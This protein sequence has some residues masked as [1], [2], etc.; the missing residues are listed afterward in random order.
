MTITIRYRF[1]V[2]LLL[3]TLLC[4][5]C[6]AR[7]A[8]PTSTRPLLG[9]LKGIPQ[10]PINQAD[11]FIY[12]VDYSALESA[13]NATRPADA[14]EFAN[15]R[16]GDVSH[17]VWGAVWRN[18]SGLI[19]DAW[20]ALE[21]M[22]Q[23]VG[24]SALE[25]DQ[26]AQFGAPPGQG[27]ILAGNFDADAIRAA[28]QTN[29]GL[30]S[31]DLDGQTVWCWTEDCADGAQA[32]A[33]SRMME[34]PFGGNLGQRQPMIISDD[35]LMAATD[36]ELVL[37]HQSAAAGKLPNL[38][39]DPNY[40]AA[41]NAIHKDANVLQAMI[42]NPAVAQRMANKL[43]IDERLPAD[44]LIATQATMLE[45][46]QELPPFEL[47]IL[48]DAVTKDEQIA[49]LGIVYKDAESAE[50]A[51]PILLDRLANHQT[52][53][54]PGAFSEMLAERHVTNPRYYVHPESGRAVLVLE[55]AA[56]KATPDEIVPML[57]IR[58]QGAAT[59]PGLIFRLFMQMFMM[60][61]ISW[62]SSAAR[63]E[64]EAMQVGTLV[65]LNVSMDFSA[66]Q[67]GVI[68]KAQ[69]GGIVIIELEDGT[70]VEAIW[71]K[72]LGDQIVGG[73][74]L[75]VA[76]TSDPDNWKVLKIIETP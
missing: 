65:G 71:D 20:F 4:S 37:A 49:R 51:A 28:Y 17:K 35:L 8:E 25:V 16:A 9:L 42:A 57:D 24:F 74:Q 41:V 3:V 64:F 18:L 38:A 44:I 63:T 73:M 31:R 34:N 30:Q 60:D 40:L 50:R 67:S 33:K 53:T 58:Y 75:L 66:L 48:A 32:D 15:V 21:T 5:A 13:Y 14:K 19:Q 7:Q 46:F 43:P 11:G 54:K 23:K 26:A 2:A 56:P 10:D 69:F 12:F 1:N 55:F 52:I 61:D 36:V 27:L 22:P 59:P 47:L 62:L 39:D 45:N 29:F 68:D 72:S 70:K 6:G 76:P